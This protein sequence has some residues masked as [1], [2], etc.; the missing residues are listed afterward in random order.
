MIALG[1]NAYFYQSSGA[2]LIVRITVTKADKPFTLLW[3]R[4]ETNE[5]LCDLYLDNSRQKTKDDFSY[6][7]QILFF[8]FNENIINYMKIDT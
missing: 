5:D 1:F 4:F 3:V 7:N 8:V 6:D 2:V